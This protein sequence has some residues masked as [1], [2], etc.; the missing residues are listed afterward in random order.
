MNIVGRWKYDG[1]V[2]N[3]QNQ[4]T[5]LQIQSSIFSD[6][7][8]TDDLEMEISFASVPDDTIILSLFWDGELLKTE[9]YV[10]SSMN[11]YSLHE[12]EENELD[13][14]HHIGFNIVQQC[15][16]SLTGFAIMRLGRLAGEIG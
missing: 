3:E 11:G 14:E 13:T 16:R 4:Q 10:I 15:D 5:D 7:E 8:F 12:G 2:S 1:E 9:S 6:V